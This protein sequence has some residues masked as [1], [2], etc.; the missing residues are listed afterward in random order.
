MYLGSNAE[1]IVAVQDQGRPVSPPRG[2]VSRG[3]NR[4]RNLRPLCAGLSPGN[5]I[6]FVETANKA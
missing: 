3:W 2:V 6:F 5:A 4:W 1:L